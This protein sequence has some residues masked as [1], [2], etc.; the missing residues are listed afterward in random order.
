MNPKLAQRLHDARIALERLQRYVA[1]RTFADYESDDFLRSAVERQ[2]EVLAEALNAAANLDS[3]LI[4]T[5]PEL[6]EIV[7]LRNR[8]AHEYDEL[9]DQIIWDAV[10]LDVPTLSTELAKVWPG[11]FLPAE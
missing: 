11:L 2:F 8:I 6:R 9:D 4:R 10:T 5:V 1:G 7:G 3:S